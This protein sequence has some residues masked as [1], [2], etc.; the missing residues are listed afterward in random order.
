MPAGFGAAATAKRTSPANTPFPQG[1]LQNWGNA[2]RIHH[3]G[4]F[5]RWYFHI[6]TNGVL[7][8]VGEVVTQGPANAKSGGTGRAGGLHLHFQVQADSID[9]GQSV[10]HTFEPAASCDRRYRDE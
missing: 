3:P 8:Q 1:S 9:W 7:V 10:A 4:G 6:Q 2:V 5:T